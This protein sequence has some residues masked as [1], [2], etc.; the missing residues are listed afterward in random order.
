MTLSSVQPKA[1]EQ[2]SPVLGVWQLLTYL[3]EVKE[4]GES[5]PPMGHKPMGY[6]IFTPEGRLSFTL[7]AEGRQPATTDQERAALLSSVIAYTGSY[8]LEGNRWI[9]QVDVAWNPEWVGTEQTRYFQV[10]A[11]RLTVTTPWRV[12]PNWPE[13]GLTRSIVSFQRCH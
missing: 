4:S 3:V 13:K 5:F 9:T 8:R 7:S 11:D 10:E 1:S 2:T 12:M 6:V